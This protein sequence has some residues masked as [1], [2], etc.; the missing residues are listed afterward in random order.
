M[1]VQIDQSG[2]IEFTSKHTVLALSNKYNHSILISAKVKRRAQEFFRKHG[3]PNLFVYQTFAI[4]VY[5]LL[6]TKLNEIDAVII[7]QEYPGHEKTIK[8][9]I[10]ELLSLSK[11]KMPEII[12]QR[13]GKASNAHKMAYDCFVKKVKADKIIS[14][15]EMVELIIFSK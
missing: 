6:R 10:C 2:K 5:L 15:K 12:F 3:R 11:L 9:M 1:Q 13:I 8:S 7:D 14:Y 4:G